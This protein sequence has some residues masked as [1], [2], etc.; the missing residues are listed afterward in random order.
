MAIN[1]DN[2]AR[3][4]LAAKIRP[5]FQTAKAKSPSPAVRTAQ[6]VQGT[7]NPGIGMD[8]LAS[9]AAKFGKPIYNYATGA[10]VT[11]GPSAF[12]GPLAAGFA[13]PKMVNALK[14][15]ATENLGHNITFGLASTPRTGNMFG[16]A[17]TGAAA[18]AALGSIIPGAGTLIGG[19]LGGIGGLISGAFGGEEFDP[20]GYRYNKLLGAPYSTVQSLAKQSGDWGD[21]ARYVLSEYN[22]YGVTNNADYR[23]AH[24]A[25]YWNNAY[26]DMEWYKREQNPEYYESAGGA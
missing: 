7:S 21:S 18:G 25:A 24:D 4:M 12:L 16:G 3:L 5:A 15:D 26:K 6:P 1:Y 17:A 19:A 2:L 11:A 13:T 22:K 23:K 10:T 8:D 20:Y 9:M 14:S